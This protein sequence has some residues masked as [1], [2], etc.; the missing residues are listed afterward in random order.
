MRKIIYTSFFLLVAQFCFGQD[1]HLSQFYTAQLNLNP[2]L[3]G[4]YEGDYRLA[5]N[6]R[7]QWRALGDPITTTTIAFDHKI[8]FYTDEIDAGIIIIQ[9]QFSGFNLNTSKIL[10]SGSYKRQIQANVLRAGIQFGLVL[11]ATDLTAQTFPNQWVY[12]DGIFDPGVDNLED[13]LRQNQ[14]FVDFNFGVAWSRVFAN[15]TPTVGISLF[16][17]N[18]PKDTYF[19]VPTERLRMRKVIHGEAVVKLKN[20][21]T[22]EPKL[23]IMV[24]NKAQDLVVGSLLKKALTDSKIKTLYGGLLYRDGFARNRDALIPVVGISVDKFDLGINYDI[25]ISQLSQQSSLKSS[26]ELSFIYTAPTFTPKN[27]SIPCNR[28]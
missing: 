26:F 27:L 2:A 12:T 28:Y 3:G 21:L 10:L 5:S 18:R 20:A 7:N 9:D 14:R 23:M 13:N 1:I 22:L 15:F 25:H 6:Y 24:G 11:K 19:D 4:D 16:H 8:H 17:F